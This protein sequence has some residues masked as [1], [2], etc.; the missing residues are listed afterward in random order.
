MWSRPGYK[1]IILT[2][3]NTQSI[4]HCNIV[5]WG[6]LKR[7]II[8]AGLNNSI[9]AFQSPPCEAWSSTPS[10]CMFMRTFTNYPTHIL[11]FAI[12]IDLHKK[13]IIN[14]GFSI[15]LL[16]SMLYSWQ[17]FKDYLVLLVL[18]TLKFIY[19]YRE[20]SFLSIE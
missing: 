17:F 3:Q 16:F 1:E 2:T 5:H 4:K 9:K 10:P 6:I 13:T 11:I 15:L 19:S 7:F 12:H 20:C 8:R 14:I 18:N